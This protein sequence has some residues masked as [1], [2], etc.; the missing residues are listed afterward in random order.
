MNVLKAMQERNCCLLA[1]HHGTI[2]TGNFERA[3]RLAS[4]LRNL[5]SVKRQPDNR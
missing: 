3:I 1:N 5:L 4:E 2:A